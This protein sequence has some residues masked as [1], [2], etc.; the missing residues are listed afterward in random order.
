M[1][2][3]IFIAAYLAPLSQY[4]AREIIRDSNVDFLT[5]L[6]NEGKF[7]NAVKWFNN[8]Y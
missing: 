1:F 7:I 6:I 3:Q 2:I 8:I 5:N 4:K